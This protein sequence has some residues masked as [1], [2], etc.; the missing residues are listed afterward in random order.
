[1]AEFDMNLQT[2][3]ERN[4]VSEELRTGSSSLRH[5]ELRPA[6]TYPLGHEQS[7]D[8]GGKRLLLRPIRADDARPYAKMINASD[9]SSVDFRFPRIRRPLTRSAVTR[10]TQIDY[11]RQ[12]AFVAADENGAEDEL[13]G[14]VHISGSDAAEFAIFVHPQARRQG[15]GRALLLKMDPLLRGPRIL[16]DHWAD[17]TGK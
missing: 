6:A 1:L 3:D 4:A 17:R 12:M 5:E 11:D 16:G 10:C 7:F 13:F 14:E 2:E 15:I 9:A 8:G